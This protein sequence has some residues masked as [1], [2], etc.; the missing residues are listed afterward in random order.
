[1]G[2]LAERRTDSL[3]AGVRQFCGCRVHYLEVW[4]GYFDGTS[5]FEWSIVRK[6]F[7]ARH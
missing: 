6:I 1:M 4:E 2:L 5:V 7:W 3:L